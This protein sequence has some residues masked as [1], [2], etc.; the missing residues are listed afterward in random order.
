MPT[1]SQKP[2]ITRTLPKA[3]TH[4]ARVVGFIYMGTISGEYLGQPLVNQKI[5]LTWELPEELH[6]FKEGEDAKPLV[7]SEEYTLSMGK[8]SKLRPVVE[9][10]IGVSLTDEE[11]YGFDVETLLNQPCLVSIKIEET[12]TGAKFAKIASTSPLMKGQVCKE[13]FNPIKKLTYEAWDQAQFDALPKFIKDKMVTS[14][15]YK[16]LKGLVDEEN[17]VS[18]GDAIPF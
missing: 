7:H 5:R 13:A 2:T 18:T 10:M 17:G 6:A 11:A 3:G 14:K 1:I 12:K 9:G 15:E 8:K 4:I 16:V